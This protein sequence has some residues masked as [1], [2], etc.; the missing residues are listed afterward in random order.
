MGMNEAPLTMVLPLP[1]S[2]NNLYV[3]TANGR[4]KTEQGKKYERDVHEALM[5]QRSRPKCPKPP[6][7]VSL[8][9]LLPDNR[10]RDVSNM[11]KAIEDAVSTYLYYDDSC[12]HVMHLYKAL[13]KEEPRAIMLLEHK[14]LAIPLPPDRNKAVMP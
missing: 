11:V 13:D 2:V 6:Y 7:E 8:W 1:P 14:T 10:R 3:N 12:H 4:R 5:E 9:F